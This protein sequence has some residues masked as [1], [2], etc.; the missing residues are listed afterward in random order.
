MRTHLRSQENLPGLDKSKLPA[1]YLFSR[2][3]MNTIADQI[4]S[5][6]QPLVGL[7]LSIARRGA[8]MRSFHFGPIKRVKNGTVG[9][10]A[11]HIQCPW[12]LEGQNGIV[13]G[14]SDLWEPAETTSDVDWDNW[15][16]EK[17]GNLQDNR[18][19]SVLGGYDPDTR[20]LMNNSNLLVVENIY[21]DNYAGVTLILSGGY[22]L[23]IFPAGSRGEDWRL[24]GPANKGHHFV[25]SGG[26]IEE[27]P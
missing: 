12:R 5:Q 13:T 25:I 10:Y 19:G 18:L 3:D 14:R 11:L 15:N 2:I 16:Y 22:R 27:Y 23:V 26:K 20:S 7:K 9:D 8:D 17:D 1:R 4:A 6:L 24:L 21:T